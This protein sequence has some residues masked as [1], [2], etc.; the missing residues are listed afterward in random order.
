MKI[1]FLILINFI[2]IVY[3]QADK[4]YFSS[5][6]ST[7]QNEK[8]VFLSTFFSKNIANAS[9]N[10]HVTYYRCEWRAD[11]AI[12]YIAGTVTC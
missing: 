11:P 3:G 7:I 4:N 8:K 6:D 1:A 10:F 9:G 2:S 12:R 5:L